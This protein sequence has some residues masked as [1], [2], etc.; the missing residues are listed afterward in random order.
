MAITNTE[1]KP[2]EDKKAVEIR[3]LVTPRYAYHFDEKSF[4]VEVALPGVSRDTIKIKALHDYFNLS[5]QRGEVGYRLSLELGFEVDPAKIS[6][7]YHEGLL[8]IELPIVDP[9]SQAVELKIE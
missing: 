9:M 4:V 2:I 1:S 5:A 6:A 8:R 3:Y 7:K